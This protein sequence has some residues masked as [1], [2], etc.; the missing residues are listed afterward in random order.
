M[1]NIIHILSLQNKASHV[2]ID[3]INMIIISCKELQ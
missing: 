3:V 1:K 2:Y